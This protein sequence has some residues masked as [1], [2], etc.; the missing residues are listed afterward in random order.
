MK[1]N[2]FFILFLI[3]IPFTSFEQAN[4]EPVAAYKKNPAIPEFKIVETR[5]T[6]ATFI[7]DSLPKL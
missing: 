2:I 6:T 7:R 3:A 5:D 1:K 4:G